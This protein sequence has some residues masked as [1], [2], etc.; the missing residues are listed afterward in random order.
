MSKKN[1]DLE[2]Q[3]KKRQNIFDDYFNLIE[4]VRLQH[5]GDETKKELLEQYGL[6]EKSITILERNL[7]DV[8]LLKEMP[9]EKKKHAREKVLKMLKKWFDILEDSENH[10][11]FLNIISDNII[12]IAGLVSK[13]KNID[14]FLFERYMAS[15]NSKAIL[16]ANTLQHLKIILNGFSYLNVFRYSKDLRGFWGLWGLWGS[17]SLINSGKLTTLINKIALPEFKNLTSLPGFEALIRPPE[18]EALIRSPE[19]WVLIK[20]L[21]FAPL[22]NSSEF[23]PLINSQEFAALV[24]SPEFAALINSPEF[25]TL[26]NSPEFE[27]FVYFLGM[28]RLDILVEAVTPQGLKNLIDR[29]HLDFPKLTSVIKANNVED[30]R[31]WLEEI[32][33]INWGVGLGLVYTWDLEVKIDDEKFDAAQIGFLMWSLA[34]ALNEIDGVSVELE[35][36]G[37]GSK[38]FK[39]KVTM[40]NE[41]AKEEVKQILSKVLAK[42]IATNPPP[43]ALRSDTAN[44]VQKEETPTI[45]TTTEL[46]KLELE[47][48]KLELEERKMALQ[49][50]KLNY[51]N[52]LSD[53][54]VKGILQND[55]DLSI[56]INNLV[57]GERKDGVFTAGEDIEIIDENGGFGPS[58]F[59]NPEREKQN[60]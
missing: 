21:E 14:G 44:E 17:K 24:N 23:T 41:T 29:L 1:I 58:K 3:S 12:I 50:R 53:L 40:Q 8:S 59:E 49:E 2:M 60:D 22:I 10:T 51:I 47:R 4:R 6:L 36:W 18:F 13:L 43:E 27:Y 54:V 19:F 11:L 56:M 39:L 26:I 37:N 20:S 16:S 15:L 42:L 55:S 35:D 46:K 9:Q 33:W 28:R 31:E 32:D 25:E 7:D 30:C 57:F 52:N 5:L 48:A 45:D 34:G 38:W